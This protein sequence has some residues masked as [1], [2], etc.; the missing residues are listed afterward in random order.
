MPSSNSQPPDPDN[1]QR[2]SLLNYLTSLFAS[3][4]NPSRPARFNLKCPFCSA[5]NFEI[6]TLKEEGLANLRCVACDRNHLLFDSPLY[7]FDAIQSAY[8]PVLKCR[9]KSTSFQVTCDFEYRQTGDVEFIAA[10]TTCAACSFLR[11]LLTLDIDYSPT[12]HL[13]LQPLTYCPN[14]KIL[15]ALKDL[16]LYITHEDS[17]RIIEYLASQ[18]HCSFMAWIHSGGQWVKRPHSAAQLA[19]MIRADAKTP[20]ISSYSSIDAIFPAFPV[21]DDQSQTLEDRDLYWKR[22][23]VVHLTSPFSIHLSTAS[24]QNA[25]LFYIKFSNEFIDGDKLSPKPAAFLN[26]T[27]ALLHWLQTHFVSWRGKSSFDNPSEHKRI[28]A[29]KYTRKP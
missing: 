12:D 28:F 5:P 1:P 16:T 21:P 29:D 8:P 23:P 7:W 18:H 26:A 11:D 25:S 20:G 14:P 6:R 19:A 13:L 3:E 27:T 4:N 17:A 15:Y 22:N 9:C 10:S 24:P 2:P